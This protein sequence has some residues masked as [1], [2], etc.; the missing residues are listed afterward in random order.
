MR[1]FLQ[2]F[3]W[4][5]DTN[6]VSSSQNWQDSLQTAAVTALNQLP[7]E[8]PPSEPRPASELAV[9][10]RSD[11]ANALDPLRPFFSNYKLYI[12]VMPRFQRIEALA[13]IEE[14]KNAFRHFASTPGV[15]VLMPSAGAAFLNIIDPF[16]ALKQLAWTPVAPP[17][18]VC[19]TKSG[20][21]VALPLAEAIKYFDTSLAPILPNALISEI[22]ETLKTAAS[23]RKISRLLHISDVHF[24]DRQADSR[25]IYLQQHLAKIVGQVDRV[26]ISGDLFDS[27][28]KRRRVRFEEFKTGLE[29][30]TKQKVIVVPGNHDVRFCGNA[31]GRLMRNTRYVYDLGFE[32][33]IIDHDSRFIFLCFDSCE[34]GDFARGGVSQAQRLRIA[35]RLEQELRKDEALRHYEKIAIVHHHPYNYSSEPTVLYERVLDKTF[36]ESVD[37]LKFDNAGEFVNWC[38]ARGISLV[39]HGHKHI[40]H[41]VLASVGVRSETRDLMIVGCGSSTGVEEKPM[42]YDIVAF[43]QESRQWAVSFFHDPEGDG[44]GF[45]AQN[46]LILI[47]MC[48]YARSAMSL[49]R[50]SKTPKSSRTKAANYRN[51]RHHP[52][53][54]AELQ[55]FL[56]WLRDIGGSGRIY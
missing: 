2:L 22:D 41:F 53:R 34:I 16:P 7:P 37:F 55:Q 27:P 26:I 20:A 40:P 8:P 52:H 44:S 54:K 11:V 25:L 12:L 51:A 24:G 30:W 48:V 45:A 32:P 47:M 43:D 49:Q 17:A 39:L 56:Q 15:L 10:T 35:S 29:N 46:V 21:S 5:I 38:G 4:G 19:W 23:Q 28:S 18:A 9:L 1:S 13:A 42:C 31:I 3:A 33:L 14:R 36:G 6:T 50:P